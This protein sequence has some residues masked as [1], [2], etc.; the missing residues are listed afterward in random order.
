MI[1]I[2]Q[3]K[4]FMHIYI[5]V[6]SDTGSVGY[7]LLQDIFTVKQAGSVSCY[8]SVISLV[9]ATL[10]LYNDSVT[11]CG[12]H[13]HLIASKVRQN[14]PPCVQLHTCIVLPQY[15]TVNHHCCQSNQR[16]MFVYGSPETDRLC[17]CES[18]S[19]LS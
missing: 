18:F 6:S 12:L 1:Q 15:S 17:I 9:R 3:T 4:Q 2:S 5:M 16:E 7:G 13:D 10:Q 19:K 8:A 14:M 11:N